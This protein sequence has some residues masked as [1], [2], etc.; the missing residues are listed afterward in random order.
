[1]YKLQFSFLNELKVKTKTKP[2]V[3]ISAWVHNVSSSCLQPAPILL[4]IL[5]TLRETDQIVDCVL[6]TYI[7]DR[8]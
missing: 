3:R 6:H 4:L 8:V 7:V 2:S 1:M 5:Y